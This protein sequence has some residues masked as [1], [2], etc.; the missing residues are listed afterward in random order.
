M[1][2]GERIALIGDN[3]AGKSTLIKMVMDEEYPDEGRIKLGPAVK[4]ACLPQIIHFDHPDWNLVENLQATR[5]G[6]TETSARNR[7]ASYDFRGEDV[8]KSVSVLSGGEKSRL[9]LC[10]LMDGEINF[11]ILD[12]PTNH[13]D[14]DSRE[15]IEDAVESFDGTLLFVSHDRYFINRFATR[16]WEIADG[17]IT[18]WPM[19]FARYRE[20][21]EREIQR[22][23]ENTK[24]VKDKSV[25]K[26]P[27]R[28][29]REQTAAR[30][31]LVI[32]ERH[33]GETEA[34]LE[35]LDSD[36]MAA[37]C[38][39]EKLNALLAEKDAVQAAL[40]ELYEKWEALSE[41]AE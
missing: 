25:T 28:S 26:K 3:G 31:Q 15:W 37:A 41:A 22:N 30:K 19:G 4:A 23:H 34:L 36:M 5:R 40:D 10:M 8:F 12:E 13:L 2:G 9:R 29:G 27:P 17:T 7:L 14:I 6:M 33:I 16:I 21:K 38:D 39:Y 20:E 18:D 32:C 24:A 1:E 11:L 35:K